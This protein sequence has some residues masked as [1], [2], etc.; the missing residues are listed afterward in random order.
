MFPLEDADRW[1]A[2]HDEVERT[3]ELIRSFE[4]R[5]LILIDDIDIPE[6]LR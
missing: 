1:A 3:C 6:F 2:M 5:Y 4:G